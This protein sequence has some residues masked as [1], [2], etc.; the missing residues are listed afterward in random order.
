MIKVRRWRSL[1]GAAV[2]LVGL[3]VLGA[4]CSSEDGGRGGGFSYRTPQLDE[5]QIVD[6][7]VRLPFEDYEL[8]AADRIRMQDG[9]TR[10]LER[11]MAER[12]FN[13]RIGGDYTRPAKPIPELSFSDATMWGGPFGTLPLEHARRYGY[14]PEPGGPFVKGPGFYLSSPIN[15]FLDSGGRGS[16]P[17]VEAAFYGASAKGDVT[18]KNGC[19]DEVRSRL[20]SLVDTRDL[21]AD[22]NKLARQ[23]PKVEAATRAWVECMRDRGYDYTDVWSASLEFSLQAVTQRQIEVAVDDVECTTESGWA[24]YF[25]AAVA[26]Y[27]RQTLEHDP[28]LMESGLAAEKDRVAA[29][30]RELGK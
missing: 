4:S 5:V 15:R 23:H 19:F 30:E 8:S 22:V 28:A 7:A 3:G 18:S 2:A 10:L 24:N 29:V 20:G 14:K 25:Y 9:E 21:V 26:D 16:K 12:G 6:P 27:Q 17:T 13:V 1:T 11:C